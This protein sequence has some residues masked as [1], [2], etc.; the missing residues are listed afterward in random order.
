MPR[1]LRFGRDR[2]HRS[3]CRRAR[4]VRNC[5]GQSLSVTRVLP[6]SPL[7][8][9]ADVACRHAFRAQDLGDD[10]RLAP[11]VPL[12]LGSA[13]LWLAQL[14]HATSPDPGSVL[15]HALEG[16]RYLRI[17]A[18]GNEASPEKEKA[19]TPVRKLAL[20]DSTKQPAAAPPATTRKRIARGAVVPK[21]P[22][23]APTSASTR[24]KV[25][26]RVRRLRGWLTIRQLSFAETPR[27]KVAVAEAEVSVAAVAVEG[28]DGILDLL[29][30]STTLYR[31][32][33]ECALTAV[34]PCRAAQIRR[35]TSSAS[36]V[37]RAARSR[38]SSSSAA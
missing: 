35:Q 38:S 1:H 2:L 17:V 37:N 7:S 36:S 21:S 12:S 11:V 25:S 27:R 24:V 14:A 6:P 31:L 10:V 20:R 19:R 13:N 32:K 29:G 16:L 33:A 5:T 9:D 18:P 15:T 22:P 8:V 28:L 3:P 34:P 26:R 30:L 23:K 4:G